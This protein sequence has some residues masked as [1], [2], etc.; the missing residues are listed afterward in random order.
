MFFIVLHLISQNYQLKLFECSINDCL[1]H[2][3]NEVFGFLCLGMVIN[4]LKFC[5]Q[6]IAWMPSSHVF[7]IALISFLQQSCLNT[8]SG[9]SGYQII[10]PVHKTV[11]YYTPN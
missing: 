8:L 5:V 7:S 6:A 10:M 2:H 4:Q 1:R 9:H 3:L 11:A